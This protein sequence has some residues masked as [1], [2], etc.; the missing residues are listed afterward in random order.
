MINYIIIM[1]RASDSIEWSLAFSDW[2]ATGSTYL[3]KGGTST[4]SPYSPDT[5]HL[6]GVSDSAWDF[7]V[8]L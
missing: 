1:N 2:N 3:D 4:N 8:T 7:I 5:I 6:T